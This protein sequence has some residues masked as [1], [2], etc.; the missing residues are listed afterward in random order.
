MNARAF[1]DFVAQFESR[2][3]EDAKGFDRHVLMLALIGYTFFI[4]LL[5]LLAY[6]LYATL[7][8]KMGG[9]LK[10]KLLLG[11]G[12][13]ALILGF[14]LVR[15]MFLR[16]DPP[17][18]TPIQ[19]AQAPQLFTLLDEIQKKLKGPPIHEVRVSDEFNACVS[20]VPRLG[21]L[22]WHRNYLVVG[23]PFMH[24]TSPAEFAAVLAHEYGHICGAHSKASQWI[25]TQRRAWS[26]LAA[27]FGESES[28]IDW[29]IVKFLRWHWPRFNAASFVLGRQ[30]EYEADGAAVKFA[31]KEAAGAALIRSGIIGRF[32]ANKFWPALYE[33]Q[34]LA[35]SPQWMPIN[36]SCCC[37]SAAST[38]GASAIDG[39]PPGQRYS[40][41]LLQSRSTKPLKE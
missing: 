38:Y 37:P 35:P 31:G 13:P 10:F 2:S 33:G 23:L 41:L 24:G 29:V 21:M 1:E 30:Q 17:E 36:P 6:V 12:I 26:Q 27:R 16:F 15:A 28:I 25:Y 22:G 19:R 20:Q 5:M 8:A 11:L 4:G 32:L 34:K 3:R 39:R 9:V 7:T 18:G 40:Q 14:T